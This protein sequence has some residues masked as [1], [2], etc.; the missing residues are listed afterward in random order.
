MHYEIIHYVFVPYELNLNEEYFFS[1]E[2]NTISKLW[3]QKIS[4]T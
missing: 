3:T 4:G 1:G 2:I